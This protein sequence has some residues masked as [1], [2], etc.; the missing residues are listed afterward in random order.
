MKTKISIILFFTFLFV[1]CDSWKDYFEDADVTFSNQT[2]KSIVLTSDS[3][4]GE[5]EF[6]FSLAA[7]STHTGSFSKHDEV[8]FKF[9]YDGETYRD[10]FYADEDFTY[11]FFLD[12]KGKL[13]VKLG[14]GE[15]KSPSK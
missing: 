15:G 8:Y 12:S 2:S 13:K 10:G 4:T 6:P 11:C 7:G 1:S 9:T 5:S 3:R 14:A